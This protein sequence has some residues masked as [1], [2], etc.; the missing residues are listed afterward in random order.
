MEAFSLF[1][2]LSWQIV[3]TEILYVAGLI[4]IK[5]R[6]IAKSS[7][8]KQKHSSSQEYSQWRIVG[9]L[10]GH[11]PLKMSKN[12]S[13]QIYISIRDMFLNPKV[14]YINLNYTSIV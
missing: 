11:A 9:E 5:L 10:S 14:V 12:S 4:V 3:G 1:K 7:Q 8:I 6:A 2:T 13:Y